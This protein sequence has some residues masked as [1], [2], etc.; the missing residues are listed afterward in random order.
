MASSINAS[1]S[2]AGGVITTADN[3]GILNLQSSGA[4]IATVSSTGLSLATGKTLSVGGAVGSPFS[5]KN[6]IINGNMVI[7]QR[8]AGASQSPSGNTFIVDRFALAQDAASKF[9]CQQNAGSVTPPAGFKNY[10]GVTST[11]AYSPT[12]GQVFGV[13][14]NIEGFNIADLNWGSANAQTVTISFWVRSSLTGTFGGSLLNASANRSYPFTYSISSANTWEQK[15]V[16]IIGDTTGTWATDNS[17]GI[18]LFFSL[19]AGTGRSSTAGSWQAGA[20][21]SVTGATSVVGTNGATFYITGVQLEQGSAATSFEWLP[22]GQELML[23]QRYYEQIIVG[24]MQIPSGS[25]SGMIN[26][27]SFHVQ[28]RA[29]P[30]MATITAATTNASATVQLNGVSVNNWGLQFINNSAANNFFTNS[31]VYSASAEL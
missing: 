10:A 18:Q 14:Q 30:T 13:Y 23:C 2:G 11:S 17:V 31:P 24:N 5:M 28:K 27:I 4:T 26:P 6:R 29:T 20:F 22:I 3:T 25:G 15:T 19:G 8:N 21:N 16:T 1:T 7:D 12:S 9:T